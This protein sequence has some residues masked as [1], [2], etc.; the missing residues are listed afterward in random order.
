[1]SAALAYGFRDPVFDAQR[2]F[3]AVMNALARPGSVQGL[4]VALDPPAPLT[5]GLAAIAL[6]LADHEAPL[7][8]DETLQA[9]PAADYLRFHTGAAIVADPALAAFALV[10]DPGRCPPL[11]AFAAG[12]QDYPDRSTPLVLAVADLAARSMAI[13][14]PGIASRASFAAAPLPPDFA[15]Q[16]RA[17]GALFPRGVDCLFTHG[18]DVVGLPRTTRFVGE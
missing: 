14:G 6:T 9:S 17:N 4:G 12:T 18:A 8:L 10:A 15:A 13:E 16:W 2:A 5:P 3:R 1:M 11:A 7:W